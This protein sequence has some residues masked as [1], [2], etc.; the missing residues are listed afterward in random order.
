[1]AGRSTKGGGVPFS[2]RAEADPVEEAAGVLVG[3][4]VPL[5]ADAAVVDLPRTQSALQVQATAASAAASARVLRDAPR[6]ARRGALRGR[7]AGRCAPLVIT[8]APRRGNPC[9]LVTPL[10]AAGRSNGLASAR[11]RPGVSGG[12]GRPG[13]ARGRAPSP[14]RW[15]RGPRGWPRRSGASPG[16]RVV[17]VDHHHVRAGSPSPRRGPSPRS[18]RGPCTGCP[19][20]GSSPPKASFGT[21]WTPCGSCAP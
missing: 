20:S 8:A 14:R 10:A 18:G 13:R 2:S 11:R 19:T 4:A 1:M 12:D 9:T 15:P 3:P 17:Q 6:A 16:Q 5:H 7:R 21:S